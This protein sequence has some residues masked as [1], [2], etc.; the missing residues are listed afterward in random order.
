M[1]ASLYSSMR[2]ARSSFR[3]SSSSARF[4][5]VMSRAIFDAPTTLPAPSKSGETVSD[6]W[7]WLPSLRS[8]SVSKDSTRSPRPMAPRILGSSSSWPGGS[9]REIDWPIISS[10][11]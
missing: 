1:I 10:A 5:S 11:V 8:L 4:V 7:M 2:R 6:T 9:S 3:R